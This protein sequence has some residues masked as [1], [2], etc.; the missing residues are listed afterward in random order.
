MV[1]A[2]A[3]KE[4]LAKQTVWS[5][6]QLQSRYSAFGMVRYNLVSAQSR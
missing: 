6:L 1:L 4:G 3:P 5:A 2:S